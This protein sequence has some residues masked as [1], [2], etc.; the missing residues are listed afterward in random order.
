MEKEIDVSKLYDVVESRLNRNSPPVEIAK[1]KVGAGTA[2]RSLN[3]SQWEERFV[4]ELSILDHVGLVKQDGDKFT[5]TCS[6]EAFLKLFEGYDE[7]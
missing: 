3:N 2:L 7:H 1:V 5:I 4:Q 6:E